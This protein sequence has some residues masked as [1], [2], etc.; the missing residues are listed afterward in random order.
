MLNREMMIFSVV[1]SLTVL[2]DF[3]IYHALAQHLFNVDLAKIIGFITG[4]LFSYVANRFWTFGRK[5]QRSGSLWRFILLYIIT[6]MTN[7]L[8]NASALSLLPHTSITI[9][10]AFLLATAVS[11]LLNF[12]GMKKFVFNHRYEQKD[13]V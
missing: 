5:Q 11:A 12:L 13:F 6:C 3:T 1:G 8:I 7:T 2:L 10:L 9:M 4:T